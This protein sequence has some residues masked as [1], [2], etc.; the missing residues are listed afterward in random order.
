MKK[1]VMFGNCQCSGIK[2]LLEFSDFYEHYSVV[3][4]ANWQLIDGDGSLP[5]ETI[6]SADLII[7]QPL[8]DVYGCLSTNGKNK[9]S[10]MNHVKKSCILISFPRIYNSALFPIFHKRHDRSV[11]CGTVL[12]KIT[13]E[14][15]LV[16]L[17][18]ANLLDFGFEKRLQENYDI[19]IEK[20][21]ECTIKIIDFI[22]KNIPNRK[23]FLTQEHPTTFVFAEVVRQIC[24]K[25]DIR[26]DF[27]CASAADEN[28]TELE[29]SIYGNRDTCQYPI[30][31]YA[32]RH[33]GF[34]YATKEHNTANDFYLLNAL[35]YY[36]RFRNRTFS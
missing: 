15:D 11:M 13:S 33:F 18:H 5:L 25:L 22:Y 36:R 4:Y 17:Y 2:K 9:N 27:V 16:A 8:P 26:F 35:D 21:R 29:D 34:N 28:I 7:Y 10:F 31:R 14:S 32:I 30:S 12:N 24:E 23:L 19:S 20:E 3:Q 1:C 6:R